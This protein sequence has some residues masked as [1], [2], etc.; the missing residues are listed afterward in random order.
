MRKAHI[1]FLRLLC[2]TFVMFN[3]T[4]EAGYML[5]TQRSESPLYF[6][7]LSF[8]ILC[9][10]AVPIFFMISGALLLNKQE[11]VIDVIKKRFVRI[12]ID[13]LIASVVY[14]LLFFEGEKSIVSFLKTIYNSSSTTSLWY[15][16]S[17]CGVLL[18]LP[19]LQK[20]AHAMNN[21][22]IVYLIGA[23]LIFVGVLPSL[24]VIFTQ[25]SWTLNPAFSAALLTTTNIIYL[26]AGYLLERRLL[27]D[28]FTM[29]KCC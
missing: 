5:F 11:T 8:S 13:L 17:Y 23:H 9:K 15:L 6:V 2:I 24:E 14:Y 25:S 27:D 29:K 21:L 1:D 10:I 26:F 16:Y 19:L 22:E 20:L 4:G 18:M 7:Y 28:C 12:A 3:H